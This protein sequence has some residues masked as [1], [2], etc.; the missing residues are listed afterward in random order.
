MLLDKAAE[1]GFL[2]ARC[3]S[4]RSQL[5]TYNSLQDLATSRSIGELYSSL[6]STPYAS[7]LTTASSEG[8]HHGL[9]NTF[10]YHRK[11]VFR[12]IK[13]TNLEIF[14]LFFETKY[15]MVDK[16]TLKSHE[17]NPEEYFYKI[18]KNYITML[19]KS[20]SK[21]QYT[22]Q[23][24]LKKI[25]G[26]YFDLL[27]LYNLVK[28]RLLYKLTIEET[29]TYMFPYAENFN[30]NNLALLCDINNIQQLSSK[31]EN[32]VGESF[33]SYES[34]RKVLYKYHMKRVLSIW[35]G[36]PFSIAIPF[37]LLRLIEIE[38]SNLRT[39]TEGVM[40]NIG[41]KEINEMI[42]GS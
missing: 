33:D 22:E 29:L 38:I 1:Y 3:H 26:S 30:I 14:K 19:K 24:H 13:K 39:I 11:Q 36:F 23:M 28:F 8:I 17:K 20:I 4:I 25:L 34:F 27:N 37:S 35:S 10:E 21:L 31:I 40:H 9:S 2:N 18:D 6:G 12:E 7:F 5:I 42:V 32:I 15:S 41:S 16:K